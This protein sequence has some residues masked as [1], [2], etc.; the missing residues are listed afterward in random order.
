MKNIHINEVVMWAFLVIGA[1][2]GAVTIGWQVRIDWNL[3]PPAE[4]RAVLK[5]NEIHAIAETFMREH[6]FIDPTSYESALV[7]MS[8]ERPYIFLQ[9]SYL[10][11]A[12]LTAYKDTFIHAPTV[13]YGRFF[14]PEEIE[15][16]DV[17]IDA[18]RGSIVNF[19]QILPEEAVIAETTESDAIETA[20]QFIAGKIKVTPDTLV[21]HSKEENKYPGGIER[22][23]TF[24]W[25]G[26]E[27]DSEYGKG[28]VTFNTIVRGVSVVGF[29]PSF[30]YPE[31]YERA[32]EKSGNVGSL[33]G[34]GSLLAWIFVIIASLVSMIRAFSAHKA[35]WKLSLGVVVV[36]SVLSIIDFINLYPEARAWYDTIDSMTVYWIFAALFSIFAILITALMF[37]MPSVAGVTL[38]SEKYRER[39]APLMSLPNSPDIKSK[40]RL[41][42][43]RGYLLGILF[44]GFTFALYWIGDTYLGVWY[45]Y[46]E[47][48]IISGLGSFIP[49]FTLM[50]SLGIMAAISEEVTFRLF[51]ILWI[52]SLTK[53]TTIGVLVATVIWAFAHTD[54]SVLPVW[55][56]GAEVFMGG[57][58]FAYFFMR[59]NILTTIVAHY[60]HNIIIAG[61]ILLFTF[62]I[63]QL[64]PVLLIFLMPAII[65][66]CFE[67]VVST[68]VRRSATV[69]KGDSLD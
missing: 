28:F 20:R 43:I 25:K 57:L 38:A 53:S 46:G 29:S 45:P 6:F 11:E 58:L 59:Y 10:S 21:V 41:A 47:S 36:L 2:G 39:I 22:L 31:P 65:Y 51:G 18:Y 69:A 63:A 5:E 16:Y 17:T 37:F 4:Q 34:F 40:Y 60:V 1:I 23:I 61:L 14:K 50:L 54:G 12:E 62:G 3:L 33:V 64:V 35:V 27:V 19:S 44:L 68:R 7:L 66:F 30:E 9:Q 42:L 13:Y 32:L 49:A 24:A 56:R 52:S 55:F 48:A 8:E 15:E 67:F 26:S